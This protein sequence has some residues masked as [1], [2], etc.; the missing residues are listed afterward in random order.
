MRLVAS[1][2]VASRIHAT[3]WRFGSVIATTPTASLAKIEKLKTDNQLKLGEI[4]TETGIHKEVDADEL[5]DIL[6]RDATASLPP[7]PI[8][9]SRGTARPTGR[10]RKSRPH[11]AKPTGTRT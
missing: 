6:I 9:K 1:S 5:R 2:L 4:V 8:R 11:P 7:G 3:C 10:F